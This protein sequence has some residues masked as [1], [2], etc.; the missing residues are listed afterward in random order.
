MFKV[1]IIH[2]YS[3]ELPVFLRICFSCCSFYCSVIVG[4]GLFTLD[5]VPNFRQKDPIMLI[6][7]VWPCKCTMGV[8]SH[9]SDDSD[10]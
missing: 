8:I 9:S 5:V 2:F 3:N 1:G 10:I 4:I 7:G 6:K